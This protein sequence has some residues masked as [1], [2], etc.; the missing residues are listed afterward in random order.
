MKN[1]KFCPKCGEKTLFWSEE[2]KWN[3][4]LCNFVLYHNCAAAVAVMIT[5]GDEIM[6]TRRNQNPAKGKLDLA[7]GFTD[8]N[9][10]AEHTCIRELKEELGIDIKKENLK[11]LMSLPN[12]YPYKGIDY[13]T[14]DLFFEYPIGEKFEMSLE[15]TEIS[16]IVWLKKTEIKIQDIAF[17]SQKVF[18]S[19]WLNSFS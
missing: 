3:C 13:Y 16:E 8:P 12:V 5:C 6:L 4:R 18:F 11:F 14:L 10:S 1:L 19:K 15:K 9:E 2:K 17:E 7:G